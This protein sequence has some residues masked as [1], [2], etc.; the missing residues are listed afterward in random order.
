[1]VSGA[2]YATHGGWARLGGM[3]STPVPASPARQP[4]PRTGGCEERRAIRV[5]LAE[6]VAVVRQTLTSLLGLEPDIQ[7][8]AALEAG[9]EIIPA[10]LEH[11]PDVA[12][13]D[14]GL[15]GISGLT[16]AAELA[17]SLP[18]CQVLILTGLESP[19]NLDVALRAGVRGFLLKDCPADDLIAA[20]RAVA[21]G[22]RVIDPR[23]AGLAP[24]P[25]GETPPAS[26]ASTP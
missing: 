14:I 6:D 20:V 2:G 9:D 26:D 8:V 18:A 16:A 17:Q 10:A 7:V 4:G 5:L 19:G 24:G 15:P 23:A 13:L 22:E 25:A 11:H 3:G 21:S 1:M 12:L